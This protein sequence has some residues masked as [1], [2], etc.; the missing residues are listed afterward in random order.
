[1]AFA[2]NRNLGSGSPKGPAISHLFSTAVETSS[3]V[4]ASGSRA[5]KIGGWLLRFGALAVLALLIPRI[6]IATGLS[7]QGVVSTLGTGSVTLSLPADMTVDTAGNIYIADTSNN[8][9]VRITAQGVASVFAISG[10]GTGLNAPTGVAID[11]SGNLYI[12]DSGTIA[13]WKLPRR[14]ADQWWI[15]AV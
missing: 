7:F 2:H 15:P 9:I 10:L 12:A 11:G 13:S 5:A 14:E 4:N 3:H 6:S 1:M 8:R